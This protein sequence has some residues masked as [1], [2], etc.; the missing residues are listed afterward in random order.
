RRLREVVPRDDGA[1]G[2]KALALDRARAEDAKI[3]AVGSG[4][5]IAGAEV[6][7]AAQLETMPDLP[8]AIH[9]H[10][11]ALIA[12]REAPFAVEVLGELEWHFYRRGAGHALERLSDRVPEPR[13]CVGVRGLPAVAHS[14][15]ERR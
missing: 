9:H 3:A 7:D 10:A 5:S 1:V 4:R 2:T 6:V 14:F 11:M 13:Q 8:D 15:R 12:F